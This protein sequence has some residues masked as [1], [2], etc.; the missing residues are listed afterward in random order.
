MGLDNHDKHRIQILSVEVFQSQ[1]DTI[2]DKFYEFLLQQPEMKKFLPSEELLV[3][4]KRT[5]SEY[6]ARFGVEFKSKNY[7]EYRLRIGIAHA[8]IQLPLNLY[9]AS[10]LQIQT[11]LQKAVLNSSL[12]ENPELVTDCYVTISRIIML[13]I[14]LAIDSY[15]HSTMHSLSSSVEKLEHQNNSLADQLMHDSLTG[16]LSRAYILDI[17]HKQLG[18]IQRDTDHVLSMV[19]LD[20]DHF[21]SINDQY[22]HPVG[23][24]VL[25]QFCKTVQSAIRQQD[26]FGRYGGEEFLLLINDDKP[27]NALIL[28]ERIRIMIE[29]HIYMIDSHDIKFTISIG[30]TMIKSDDTIEK[31]L[32]RVDSALYKA[33]AAGRNKIIRA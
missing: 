9:I 18:Q 27:D 20:I 31:L 24:K 10:F 29:K 17:L 30:F 22:G 16:V 12:S 21:K 5:Q 26:Y 14:S 11:L 3:R 8:R 13:D 32:Q 23:D 6:L 28:V 2:I 15:I 25:Q 7:F 19:L 4:L 1:S 33:K